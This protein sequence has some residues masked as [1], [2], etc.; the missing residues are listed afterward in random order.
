MSVFPMST[1]NINAAYCSAL[2][3]K[4]HFSSYG[5]P[6]MIHSNPGNS[7]ISILQM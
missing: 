6:A 3:K 2:F 5:D 4:R 1:Q 7:A